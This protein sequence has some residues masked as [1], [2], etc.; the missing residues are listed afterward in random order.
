[1][2]IA[3]QSDP[4]DIAELKE[5]FQT[6]DKD[7]NGTI[8]FDEL[9]GALGERENGEQLLEMLRGAD[10]DNSG[11]I[12]YTGKCSLLS[13]FYFLTDLFELQSFWRRPW[14]PLCSYASPTLRRPSRCLTLTVAAES[15]NKSSSSFL[16]ATN[17]EKC[18]PRSNSKPPSAKSTRTVTEKSTSKSSSK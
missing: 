13:S 10:A 16:P 6:I 1:M 5:I 3:V 7:G 18:T 8:T 12:D 4:N 17:S 2:A 9:Q 15:T 11:T 14:M